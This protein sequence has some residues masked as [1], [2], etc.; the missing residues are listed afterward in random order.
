MACRSPILRRSPEGSQEE[1]E[2]QEDGDVSIY[3]VDLAK[4]ATYAARDT[5]LTL[6]LWDVLQYDLAQESMTD[7]FWKTEMPFVWV[8]LDMEENGMHV[9]AGAVSALRIELEQER[10]MY[11][12]RWNELTGGT[13]N[14]N[15][16]KQL[17]ELLFK[18]LKLPVQDKTKSG[19]DISGC[20]DP[21]T[22]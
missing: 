16:S 2:G 21:A 20:P 12:T 18:K 17:G 15:S 4:L 10:D 13:I 14:H 22:P 3:D 1:D 5:R 9:N 6:K 7:L 19:A 11:L 8:L